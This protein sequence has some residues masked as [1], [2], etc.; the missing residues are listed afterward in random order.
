MRRGSHRQAGEGARAGADGRRRN[1]PLRHRAQ[2]AALARQLGLPVV[3]TFMGRGLLEDAPDVLAGTYLGAAG[4]AGHHQTGREGRRSAAARRH[5]VRHQF[6]AVAAPARSP[7]HHP[8]HG[9]QRADR[10]S[11]LSR[12]ADRRAGRRVA[13]A[14]AHGQERRARQRKAAGLS[15]RAQGRRR[16]AQTL[17]HRRRRQR[18]VRPPR[19]DADGR[20]HGRLPVHRHGDRQ[21]RAGGARLLRRHG[22]RR[23][24]RHRRRGGDAGAVR[25][26]WSA[27][28]PSR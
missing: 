24:G 12:P 16:R 25:S 2:T 4:D 7:A 19:H 8:R 14:R 17:R 15:A 21:H 6:R 10:P 27:T 13:R 5:L 1:P 26:S 11:R 20:R 22:L 3:T 28:A 9:P 23:A 18:S